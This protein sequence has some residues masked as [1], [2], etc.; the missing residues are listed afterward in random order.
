MPALYFYEMCSGFN[1]LEFA[2]AIYLA[3]AYS[4]LIVIH[5]DDF[6]VEYFPPINSR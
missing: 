1:C 3:E 2:L 4:C 5:D 6:L